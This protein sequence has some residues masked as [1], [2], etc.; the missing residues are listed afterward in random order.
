MNNTI[1]FKTAKTIDCSKS[2]KAQQLLDFVY[3]LNQ[4]YFFTI[5]FLIDFEC[6]I[7]F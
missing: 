1:D 2:R 4:S 6:S 7:I 5:D 3:S